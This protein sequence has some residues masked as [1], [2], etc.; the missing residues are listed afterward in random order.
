MEEKLLT[1]MTEQYDTIHINMC[2]T[3]SLTIGIHLDYLLRTCYTLN[4][5]A[6]LSP[7]FSHIHM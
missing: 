4:L 3:K 7:Q 1:L 5:T 6:L 2:Q